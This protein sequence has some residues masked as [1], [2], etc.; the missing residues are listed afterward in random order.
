MGE[1]VASL[2]PGL[3]YALLRPV[4]DP[5]GQVLPDVLPGVLRGSTGLHGR[6]LKGTLNPG[7]YTGVVDGDFDEAFG[8][9]EPCHV[10]RSPC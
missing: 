5:G 1:L 9:T 3:P 10:S 2:L 4:P 8:D 6:R 7:S